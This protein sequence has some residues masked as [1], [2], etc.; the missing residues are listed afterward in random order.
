MSFHDCPCEKVSLLCLARLPSFTNTSDIV[1]R[2]QLIGAI[3]TRPSTH[4]TICAA[5]E[6]VPTLSIFRN[7]L[8]RSTGQ[9]ILTLFRALVASELDALAIARAYSDA[10]TEL[11]YAASDE[12]FPFFIP[13]AWQAYLVSAIV[14]NENVLSSQAE[15]YGIDAIGGGLRVQAQRDLQVLFKLYTLSAQEVWEFTRNLLAQTHLQLQEAL[16]AWYN[17]APSKNTKKATPRDRLLQDMAER[18]NWDRVSDALIRHWSLYG[19]GIF[20]HYSVVRW[21]SH[22]KELL[23]VAH[24]DPIQL[25]DLIGYEQ[26][27][28][29]LQT[30]LEHF[31]HGSPAHDAILYGAPGT[32]KSSTVKAL[33][34]AYTNQG[35]RLIEVRK[36]YV[37][38]M[39]GIVNEVR[40]RAPHFLL[41]IDDLSFEEHETTY[42]ALKVFLEGTVEVRPSNV[43]IY[44]TTNRLNLIR[45]N[46]ADRGKPN[47]DVHW[48]DTLDEKASLVA[49][50]GLRVTFLTPDQTQ[51]MNI[52]VGLAQ[53]RGL[54]L[55]EEELRN[56]ALA[57]ERQHT[58]RSGR[59]ARQ[60]VDE[61][62]GK[63]RQ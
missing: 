38:D 57:W 23:G 5:L 60:F 61:L 2:K 8:E 33:A 6:V 62:E 21:E 13:D 10:F 17:L 32:G 58:G 7:V 54:M 49:R 37:N 50:F 29:R 45:E 22:A 51:Y 4:D 39:P 36:E 18:Q 16:V 41:F 3:M 59:L 24:P 35:L 20:A 15:R 42:K 30:N 31:L 19:T 14:D 44:A 11:A 26:E 28:Q 46:F 34:N 56:H 48:R 12:A 9:A 55:P 63:L 52:V 1:Q 53:Q 40:N 27:K 43:L 25:S 47:E